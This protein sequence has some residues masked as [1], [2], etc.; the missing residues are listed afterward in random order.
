[1]R[2]WIRTDFNDIQYFMQY[3]ELSDLLEG[4]GLAI[5]TSDIT[6]AVCEFRDISWNSH[7][8]H[9][10]VDQVSSLFVVVGTAYYKFSCSRRFGACLFRSFYH[11]Y[12]A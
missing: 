12:D 5:P 1:M 11:E 8:P 6:F 2:E 10:Y 3:D 4:E 7:F 9:A